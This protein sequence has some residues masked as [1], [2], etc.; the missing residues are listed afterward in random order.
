ML[1]KAMH[2]RYESFVCLGW[3]LVGGR[4]H[5]HTVEVHLSVYFTSP[6]GNQSGLMREMRRD[7]INR[8]RDTVTGHCLL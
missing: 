5:T 4:Q 2:N 3:V 8:S 7:T 1:V 6:P